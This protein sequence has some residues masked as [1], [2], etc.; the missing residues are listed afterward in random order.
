MAKTS[1]WIDGKQAGSSLKE[2]K[3]EV[4]DLNRE[5]NNLPQGSDKYNQK[6]QELGKAKGALQKHRQDVK[7]IADAYAPARKGIGSMLKQFAPLALGIGAVTKVVRGIGNGIKSW[8]NNNIQLSKS[9]D[10]LQSIT[11]ASADDIAFYR[12]EAVRMGKET[13]Q[14]ATQV[15]KAM[16]MI[17]SQKPELL[18]NRE[19]LAAVTEQTITLAEAA[20]ISMPEAAKAIT[21]T[22]NQFNLGAEATDR[23]INAFAAGSKEGAAGIQQIG[24][25]MDASG[26][27]MKGYNVD[28]E[29]G[30]GLIETLAEKNIQG[31]EAGTKLR[32]VLL[33]MQTA[34]ALPEKALQQLERY[35]VDIAKVTD[36]TL[37]F[38]QRL[39][40]MTK[41]SG[42]AG[43][44]LD[45]FGKQNVVAAKAILENTD[46]VAEY[47]E[48]VTGTN[49]AYEQAAINT[50][51]LAGDLKAMGSAWEGVTLAFGGTESLFRP[52]VQA[53][54]DMLNW[55]SDTVIAFKDWNTTDMET[56]FLKLA[57]A[58]PFLT[59]ELERMFDR[60]IRINELSNEVVDSIRKQAESSTV[61]TRA[62]ADNNKALEEGTLTAE[63]KGKVEEQNAEIIGTLNEQYPEL[64]ENMD[65][66]AATSEELIDLQEQINA[67]LLEQ[68]LNAVKAAEAERLLGE[69]VQRTLEQS[70]QRVGLQKT[71]EEGAS[72]GELFSIG[73]GISEMAETEE[74]LQNAHEDLVNL[75][76]TIQQVGSTIE[77][78]DMDWGVGYQANVDLASDAVSQL[79][80]LQKQL[81]NTTNERTRQAIQAQIDANEQLINTSKKNKEEMIRSALAVE[82]ANEA[83]A[84]TIEQE[85]K[86]AK[87]ASS[88][89]AKE[90]KKLQGELDK[91]IEKTEELQADFDFQKRV[92]AFQ[93]GQD[94]ELFILQDSLDKKFAAEIEA[95]EK[96]K[97]AKGAI[98]LQAQ[99]EL[100]ALLVLKQE[101]LEYGRSQIIE[102]FRLENRQKEL[103]IERE[104]NLQFLAHQESLEQAKVDLKVAK[105]EL[106]ID[107]AA[108]LDKR[109]Q[110]KALIDLQN[111]LT[112]RAQ[113]E[114]QHAL[115]SLMDQF[116][117]DLI[118]KE[119]FNLRKEEL[120]VGHQENLQ[121]VVNESNEKIAQKTRD[122]V[123]GA[124]E[125][126]GQAFSII[127]DLQKARMEQ[128][129]EEIDKEK[130]EEIEA[131]EK[132][133]DAGEITEKEYSEKKLKIEAA[134]DVKRKRAER[135][136][137]EKDKEIALF[138]AA[139]AAAL[140]VVKA[141]PNPITMALAA[142][143]GLA[144]IAI[145]SAKPVP[146]AVEGGYMTVEGAQD[147]KTYRAKNIGRPKAGLTPNNPSLALISEEGPEYFVPNSL[148]RDHRAAAHVRA[149]E[150]IRVNQ[151]AEGGFTTEGA[152]GDDRVA[153]LL[154]RNMQVMETLIISINNMRVVFDDGNIED[155]NTRNEEFSKIKGI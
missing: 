24:E 70:R 5:I 93:E 67:N 17:G 37:P 65:L 97:D 74:G 104:K 82:Q 100:N 141:A 149:I 121:E 55:V 20:E 86:K 23:V 9:L 146:Q 19:A 143:T 128:R 117:Q 38:Q 10:K 56:Q 4:A 32:N 90:L 14:S 134:A 77:D 126:I 51:N 85:A 48:A 147:G 105:A 39:E 87:K 71:L 145:I 89:A 155:L 11:G 18:K 57:S 103:D 36:D 54:T 61:L 43:A 13:T 63:E 132:S 81:A 7:E 116:D 59:D 120:E 151:F 127:S 41:I 72:F 64:T 83:T 30:I 26:A 25:S 60:Q 40:E 111:A 153:M 12:K 130:N 6:L 119:E 122:R 68:S 1:I 152:A 101:E 110:E 62:L 35:G 28:V 135:Q 8:V 21:G 136:K 109:A 139:I 144:Q 49:T 73:F 88:D 29:S 66:N 95:A 118:S 80:K 31:A 92:D 148:L 47:T 142:A 91:L 15:V 34:D 2:I 108:G 16:E 113:L 154:E 150:A 84:A 3:K 107:I 99:E 75:D 33:T 98:G 78:M 76:N 138:E 79:E 106:G 102:K 42:D 131:L 114:K 140:A 124:I 45:V 27:V 125:A 22:L 53:G 96:L 137:A 123:A 50:D 52:I 129:I 58:I 115:E 46:R 44:M 112:E 133:R 69:I 94:K